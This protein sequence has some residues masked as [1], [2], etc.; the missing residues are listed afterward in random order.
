MPE[1]PARRLLL[2]VFLVALSLLFLAAVPSGAGAAQPPCADAGNDTIVVATPPADDPIGPDGTVAV[3]HGSELVVHLCQSENSTRTLD[4]GALQWG[5]VLESTDERLRIRVEGPTND[6]LG[7]L[8]TPGTASGPSLAIV[9]RTVETSLVTGSIPV[10]SADQRASLRR[11]ESTYVQR[12]RLL[13]RQLQRL[14]NA[15]GTVEDGGEPTGDPIG[16]TMAT[17]E[18]YRNASEQFRAE[19]Y[20]VA[21]SSVGGPGS[22]AALRALGA[23]S[24]GLE[25][26]TRHRLQ[27]HDAVLRDRQRSLTWSLRLRIFGVGAIGILIGGVAGALLPIRRGRAARRRLA[28][29]EWT[30][31]SRRAIL[32]PAAV[33]LVLL[34]LGIGWLAVTFGDVIV[35]VLAP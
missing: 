15:T 10:A 2:P 23:R 8:V 16:E 9:D 20:A 22:A 21:D 30:T 34:C 19:L 35:E 3:Y 28:Q 29:G 24:T 32:L 27:A 14:E 5:T 6:S 1:V 26:R 18:A 12:E 7:T 31:Y 25:N 4:D 11:A 33:G 13:E 17:R